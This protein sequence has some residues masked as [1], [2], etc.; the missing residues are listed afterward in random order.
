MAKKTREEWKTY[1]DV[2]DQ[3]TIRTLW[4]LSSRG[5]LDG[6]KSP[7]SLGKEAN[8]FTAEKGKDLLCAKIYRLETA[9]FNSMYKYI[10]ND[11]R[12]SGLQHQRRKVIFAWCQ[13]E[14]RNLLKCKDAGISCPKPVIFKNNVLLM[15]LIGIPAAPRLKEKPPASPGKFFKLV[16]ENMKKLHKLKLVHA[17]LSEYNILNHQEKPVFIDFSHA[18]PLDTPNADELIKRD[19][20]N[21]CRYFKK[22]GVETTE[23]KIWDYINI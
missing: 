23:K 16:L 4:E 2:F 11:P 6:L 10:R 5:F 15:E 3:F 9:D 22:L 19:I 17:D 12:F 20:K 18:T 14:Y 8:V 21:I 1:Q 13:R 7:V